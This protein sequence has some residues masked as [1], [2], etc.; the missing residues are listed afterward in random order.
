MYSIEFTEFVN[1]DVVHDGKK[2]YIG[3]GNPNSKILLVGKEAAKSKNDE[4]KH[5][6]DNVNHWCCQIANAVKEIMEY[7]VHENHDL[8]PG[9]GRNTWSKYQKLMEKIRDEK[10]T[11]FYVDFLKDAF[12]TEINNSTSKRTA[13]VDKS[14]LVWRKQMFKESAFI[15]SFPVVILACS[16]YF[17][18]NDIIREIDEVFGV[19]YAGHDKEKYWYNQS[20]WF[21]LHYNKDQSRL[22]IH[23]RQLSGDVQNSL[24][25][26]MG[27]II[28]EHLSKLNHFPFRN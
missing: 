5:F 26:D 12:T 27:T 22:V 16:N 21:Y 19:T 23:T 17:T 28:R 9:W 11:R 8:R 20:N 14:S 24:L 6:N 13:S 4:I 3:I 10:S 2:S 25:K 1:K 15:Q 18:N 7:E